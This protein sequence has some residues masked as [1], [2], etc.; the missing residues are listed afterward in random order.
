[1]LTS[2]HFIYILFT[3][4]K[5]VKK[6][7]NPRPT[8]QDWTCTRYIL[9]KA[10]IKEKHQNQIPFRC[11]SIFS[12]SNSGSIDERT[13]FL[14]IQTNSLNKMDI[15]STVII[16]EVM[17]LLISLKF[18]SPIYDERHLRDCAERAALNP[19]TPKIFVVDHTGYCCFLV[20]KIGRAH[21]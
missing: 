19:D 10:R 6:L 14:T 20:D 16:M 1:M 7:C 3:H 15:A 18:I 8:D 13:N 4:D 21:V 12:R 9:P 5:I 17:S 11:L 2:I